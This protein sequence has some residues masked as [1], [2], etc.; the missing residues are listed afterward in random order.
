MAAEFKEANSVS[1]HNKVFIVETETVKQLKK[2]KSELDYTIA[3]HYLC[4]SGGVEQDF[5]TAIEHYRYSATA[6]HA[7]AQYVLAGLLKDRHDR[8]AINWYTEA[9]KQNH[10]S[11]IYALAKLYRSRLP[12]WVEANFLWS[13]FYYGQAIEFGSEQD[14][15]AA[16]YSEL[17][18]F[19]KDLGSLAT[20][21]IHAYCALSYCSEK[22]IGMAKRTNFDQADL[23]FQQAYRHKYGVDVEKNIVQAMRL[24]QQAAAEAP[25]RYKIILNRNVKDLEELAINGNSQAQYIVGIC[26][27]NGVGVEQ[28]QIKAGNFLNDALKQGY[29]D[30]SAALAALANSYS[31]APSGS[32]IRPASASE[33]KSNG[34]SVAQSATIVGHFAHSSATANI[35]ATGNIANSSRRRDKGDFYPGRSKKS[36]A[37]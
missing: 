20:D 29:F 16:A 10:P 9:A 5:G 30:A 26:Y 6:G 3:S 28:D 36:S 35:S 21:N 32:A 24:Y 12:G 19:I 4:G 27:Q 2:K 22:G 31:S 18:D 37:K 1:P 17:S 25:E 23:L 34:A 33:I 13:V 14:W 15:Y 7:Q 8:N 11:A